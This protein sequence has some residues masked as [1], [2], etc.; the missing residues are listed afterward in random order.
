MSSQN[1]RRASGSTPVV[2]SSRIS[3]SGSWIKRTAEPEL[4][5]HAA[6]ELSGRTIAERREV[7]AGKQVVYAPFALFARLPEQ[8][9]EEVRVLE[10]RECR[11]QVLSEALRQIGDATGNDVAKS[12]IVDVAAKNL[13]RAG[14]DLPDAG[15]HAQ[16]CRLAGAVRPDQAD[17]L[18][19]RNI[20]TDIVEG[21]D[22]SVAVGD[23]THSRDHRVHAGVRH[24]GPA[25]PVA[26]QRSAGV[27][28][29]T[30][31]FLGHGAE[32]SKR[33]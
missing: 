28:G 26:F 32:G 6:R 19:R 23:P 33:T 18:L 2:G 31:S 24:F 16:K 13:D 21:K 4:L 1:C 3:R 22:F 7:G 27:T 20:E 12:R 15:N 8:P 9:A 29:L 11:I 5:L 10:D 17:H 25:A 30:C 14:L